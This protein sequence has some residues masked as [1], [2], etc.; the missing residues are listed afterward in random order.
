MSIKF[1]SECGTKIEYKFSPPKFCSN[2]GAPIGIANT[3]EAKP[4]SREVT[5][6]LAQS[7]PVND[8]YT[9][10]V[11]VPDIGRLAY[12]VETY[13]N[14]FSLQG[15]LGRSQQA[16]SKRKTRTKKLDDLRNKDV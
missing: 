1:C 3:N 11:S 6:K 8:D 10:A 5:P 15:L 2:C 16:P 9:D 7:R 14:E 13:G 12:E 4:L